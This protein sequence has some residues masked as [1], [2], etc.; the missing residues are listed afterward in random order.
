MVSSTD[1]KR[2]YFLLSLCWERGIRA[3]ERGLYRIGSLCLSGIRALERGLYRIGSL[4]LSGI[5]AL[6][7]LLWKTL[8]WIS[9]V[10]RILISPQIQSSSETKSVGTCCLQGHNKLDP[11]YGKLYRV[12]LI[13]TNT[14][15]QTFW[16]IGGGF[17]GFPFSSE[18]T[19]GNCLLD[20]RFRNDL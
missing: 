10:K 14:Y 2:L 17:C 4:C 6:D 13:S 19:P 3:L 12:F 5:R 7:T 9:L 8:I 16:L 1:S 18:E 20:W 15:D 11:L